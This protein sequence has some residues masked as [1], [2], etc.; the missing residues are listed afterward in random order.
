MPNY[1]KIPLNGSPQKFKITLS[2]VDYWLTFRFANT[3]EGGWFL[4]IADAA[5]SPI[6]DGIP[7]VT[8]VDLLAQYAYLG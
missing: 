8:G 3:E 5:Q 2:G 1:F 4:Q 7:L 6:I